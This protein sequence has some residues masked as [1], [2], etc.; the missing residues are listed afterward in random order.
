MATARERPRRTDAMLGS[1]P[2][3]LAGHG[4]SG[5]AL[6]IIKGN[7]APFSIAPPSSRF[8]IR[9]PFASGYGQQH[10]EPNRRIFEGMDMT[11]LTY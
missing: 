3:Q 10:L 5:L 6:A 4:H 9:L 11:P 8:T 1:G 7:T 2:A